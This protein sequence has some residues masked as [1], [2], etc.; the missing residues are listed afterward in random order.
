MDA[1]TVVANL[2]RV[3]RDIAAAC[4]Q[5]GR[6]SSAVRLV[7]VSKRIAPELVVAACRAG[8]WDLGENRVG[9]ALERQDDMAGRLAAAGLPAH[10][11]RWH[12]I[13]HLQG[14]KV[15]R[16]SGRFSL[17]HGVDSLRLAGRLGRAAHEEGRRESVLLE[18]NVAAEVQKHGFTPES[19]PEALAEA[20]R[21]PGLEV[22]GLMTMAR[23]GAD[24][25]EL[26]RTFATLRRLAEDGRNATGLPLPELS[27]GM[28]ADFREAIAEGATIVRVGGAIFGPRA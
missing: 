6:D 3:N 5:A 27:M 1:T 18:V 20:V 22:R 2:E 9:D 19:L 4:R 16:A 10:G 13:G 24:E 11:P 7:A 28:S 21:V 26:R 25:A 12:F 15:A 8:Q 14:N 17:I 23:F